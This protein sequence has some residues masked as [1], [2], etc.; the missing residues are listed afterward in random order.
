MTRFGAAIRGKRGGRSLREAA[1]ET[2]IGWSRL[3]TYERGEDQPGLGHF[4]R[5]CRWIDVP[6]EY[7]TETIQQ[8]E[9]DHHEA[10]A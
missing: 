3:A 9:E 5:L 2:G 7:F 1:I 4:I 10:D 8:P 6:M